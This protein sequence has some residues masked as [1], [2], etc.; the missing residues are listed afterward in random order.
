MTAIIHFSTVQAEASLDHPRPERLLSAH[1]P[2]RLTRNFYT[3]ASGALSAG[4]WC[5]EP[6]RWRIAFAASKAEYF[7]VLEGRLSI[8]D[9][10]GLAVHFRAGEGGVIPAG[11]TGV[12]TVHEAVRKHYVVFELGDAQ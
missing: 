7:H 12:F 2:A 8:A 6:G 5:C 11:F 3:H 4:E 1:N 10:S 9:E